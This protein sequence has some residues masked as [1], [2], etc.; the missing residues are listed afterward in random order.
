MAPP[1]TRI[2]KTSAGLIEPIDRTLPG[3]SMVEK[4]ELERT[5]VKSDDF[6]PAFRATLA[7][8]RDKLGERCIEALQHHAKVIDA[9]LE[10][11]IGVARLSRFAEV[12][13]TLAEPLRTVLKPLHE[14][15][16]SAW[17]EEAFRE[18]SGKGDTPFDSFYP[19]QLPNPSAE[20]IVTTFYYAWHQPLF[21]EYSHQFGDRH[22]HLM[23]IIKL[24]QVIVEAAIDWL[25]Q[26][27]QV[28]EVT[29]KAKIVSQ[30]KSLEAT[31][32]EADRKHP[33]KGPGRRGPE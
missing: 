14:L 17:I 28:I 30:I 33:K 9:T 20:S 13:Q 4:R 21:K 19:L 24:R 26:Q 31:L 10:S 3:L 22:R 32:A 16:G 29:L 1:F 2:K 23:Y 7:E 11:Q 12:L 15:I 18:L 27:C 5:P 25:Q 6:L 8:V